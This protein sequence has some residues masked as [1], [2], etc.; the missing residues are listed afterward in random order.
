MNSSIATYL[1]HA[2][3]RQLQE[4]IEWLQIPSISTLPAHKADVHRA[5]EWLAAA[6]QRAGM[7]N[8]PLI[9]SDIHP[10]VYADWLHA[11]PDKPTVLI[12]GHF[13]VQPVDPIDLWHTPPFNQP[14]AG[15]ISSHGARPTTR[16]RPM[17]T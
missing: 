8:V 5:G 14:C 15:I 1:H 7:E 6:L 11:G 4:L 3:D 16:A 12:Y 17:S 2:R 9:E 10:L 13:D